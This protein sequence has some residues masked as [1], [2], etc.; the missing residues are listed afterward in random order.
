MLHENKEYSAFAV[1][2]LVND[3]H[4]DCDIGY[5]FIYRFICTW[6][7]CLSTYDVSSLIHRWIL[8]VLIQLAAN[9]CISSYRERTNVLI[10]N[11]WKK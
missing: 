2:V 11:H 8:H 10:K 1:Q 7:T 9:Q 4:E 6:L 3:T 5:R